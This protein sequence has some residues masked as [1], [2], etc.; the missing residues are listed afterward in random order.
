[1]KRGGFYKKNNRMSENA[2]KSPE[3]MSFRDR[4]K[5]FQGGGQE[6]AKPPIQRR[7]TVAGKARPDILTEE[8]KDQ[9]PAGG[10]LASRLAVF[11]Q[12]NDAKS[13]PPK[14]APKKEEEPK[15]D[16]PAKEEPAKPSGMAARLAMFNGQGKKEEEKPKPAPAK[17]AGG[18]LARRKRRSQSQLQ[19]SLPEVV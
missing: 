17:P 16:E 7:A 8:G 12:G 5:A 18:G 15:K 3:A 19:L 1:M 2:G 9:K 11:N 14:P 13:P 6:E 4:L 10:G